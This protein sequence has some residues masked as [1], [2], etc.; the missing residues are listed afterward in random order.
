MSISWPRPLLSRPRSSLYHLKPAAETSFCIS[1]EQTVSF[2][3]TKRAEKEVQD[4][5]H[6][7]TSSLISGEALL[8]PPQC[9]PART[10]HENST[11]SIH[12]GRG[13]TGKRP[14]R[15][16]L[17]ARPAG[18]ISPQSDKTQAISAQ[19]PGTGNDTCAHRKPARMA[20]RTYTC[21][22]SVAYLLT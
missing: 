14:T 21:T 3:D 7:G 8:D 9:I 11:E 4:R 13:P 5:F 12:Y 2:A 17:A 18:S 19:A 16:S 6:V 15:V 22:H 10:V 1:G 20:Y